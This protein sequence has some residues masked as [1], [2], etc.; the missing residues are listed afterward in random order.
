MVVTWRNIFYYNDSKSTNLLGHIKLD[1]VI[2]TKDG[3][4]TRLSIVSD[5][6]TFSFITSEDDI[7][8]WF[9]VIDS[10]IMRNPS[11]VA[12]QLLLAS[13]RQDYSVVHCYVHEQDNMKLNSIKE[14]L[15]L[16][17]RD[18]PWRELQNNN[19]KIIAWITQPKHLK[20]LIDYFCN[21][22]IPQSSN[23][24]SKK[25]GTVKGTFTKYNHINAQEAFLKLAEQQSELEHLAV[26]SYRVLELSPILKSISCQKEVLEYCFSLLKLST[27]SKKNLQRFCVIITKLLGENSESLFYYLLSSN[28]C[29]L[30]AL[31]FK[32]LSILKLTLSFWNCVPHTTVQ[33]NALDH[34]GK[35]VLSNLLEIEYTYNSEAF[36]NLMVFLEV[37]IR[38]YNNGKTE[39]L[40]G[41]LKKS[42]APISFMVN[43]SK[44]KKIKSDIGDSNIP[45]VPISIIQDDSSCTF[46]Q[47][48]FKSPKIDRRA[49]ELPE[50]ECIGDDGSAFFQY[51]NQTDVINT[52]ISR[53]L[54]ALNN[55]TR[56]RIT[57]LLITLVKNSPKRVKTKE[58]LSS[59]I[60]HISRCLHDYHANLKNESS[61]IVGFYR[62]GIMNLYR[63]L[64]TIRNSYLTKKLLESPMLKTV[65]HQIFLFPNSIF[66]TRIVDEL[67]LSVLSKGSQK[68]S[69]I[70]LTDEFFEKLSNL[71]SEQ[72]SGEIS[73]PCVQIICSTLL[74]YKS[75]FDIDWD[76]FTIKWN[77]KEFE[78]P[79][80]N[81]RRA[82]QSKQVAE[83]W[84]DFYFLYSSF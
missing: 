9:A 11:K 34:L 7:D 51:I 3:F 68:Y 59:Y 21:D 47:I 55:Q 46:N 27:C 24:S 67:L 33:F 19:E 62:L 18:A 23:S 79:K 29:K 8:T 50:T 43:S 63:H 2:V 78:V 6:N 56:V 70:I 36:G 14:F 57:E 38:R 54:Y 80:T 49:I 72:E 15:I 4:E 5:N 66:V 10:C 45:E 52:I 61:T 30:L 17:E 40:T 13:K 31:Q 77:L 74:K 65:I 58:D 28:A 83:N 64:V 75:N 48:K 22:G 60:I 44:L 69:N 12:P 37:L 1:N 53:S 41:R 82:T 26:Q 20:E 84:D 32:N 39:G 71:A 76:E 81:N 73:Y 16:T 42:W 25:G 35:E